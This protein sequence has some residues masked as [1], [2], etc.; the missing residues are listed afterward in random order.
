M[1]NM[2]KAIKAN[3]KKDDIRSK[4]YA[5]LLGI[6][7]TEFSK[8]IKDPLSKFT[9]AEARVIRYHAGTDISEVMGWMDEEARWIF[10]PDLETKKA[11]EVLNVRISKLESLLEQLILKS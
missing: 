4:E 2:T 6:S 1:E 11:F 8:R 10:T 3:M 5:A 9:E 7:E